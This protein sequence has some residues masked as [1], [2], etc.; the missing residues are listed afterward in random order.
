MF[1]A[2]SL[3]WL[4]IFNRI[5]KSGNMISDHEQRPTNPL[6]T[7]ERYRESNESEQIGGNCKYCKLKIDDDNYLECENCNGMVHI[8]CLHT[9]TP[10]DF[11]GDI[12]FDF[13]CITCAEEQLKQKGAP[14]THNEVK[15]RCER[16]KIPWLMVLTLTLYNLSHKQKGLGHH[17]FFHWRT[18]IISFVDRNWHYIFGPN[19][20]R[21]KKWTGSVSGTLSHNSPKYFMS[22][23]E[24]FNETGWWKLAKP[25]QTPRS[26]KR[27]YERKLELRVAMRFDK[28]SFLGDEN[29]C[30]SEVDVIDHSAAPIE[31]NKIIP[32]KIPAA[33]EA[34]PAI[35]SEGCARSIPYMGRK[36]RKAPPPVPALNQEVAPLPASTPVAQETGTGPATAVTEEEEEVKSPQQPLSSVQ[37]SLMDFLAESFGGDDLSM[38]SSLPGIMPPPLIG[39][40]KTDF[41]MTEALLESPSTS[42]GL[43]DM[44]STFGIPP[45]TSEEVKQQGPIIKEEP[46]AADLPADEASAES[47]EEPTEYQ[48]EMEEMEATASH[49]PRIV[50]VTSYQPREQSQRIKQEPMEE[51]MEESSSEALHTSS[52]RLGHCK[53]SGF[54]RQPRRNWPWLQETQEADEVAMPSENLALMSVYEEQ[55]LHQRLHRI[56]ALEQ[57]CQLSIPAYVRRLY[58]KLC[59]RK[60]KREHNRPIFNLDEHIDPTARARRKLE[61]EQQAQ[62]L[63]RYQLLAHSQQNP[64]SSFYA[65]LTGSTQYEMFESPYSQR[66]LHPFIFRSETMGPPWLKLM[67]ELQH[68]VNRCHPTR[69]PIDFCYVRPQHIPAVNALLQSAFWPNIDV[70]ECL[71]YP[72]YSVV[73]LYKKL[74]VGCGFLVPDVG[75]NEAYISFMAVRPNWQRSGIASFMLYHLIQTCMSKDITLHVSA[76]NPAV[77]LYQK[78]GFKIEEIIVDFYDK[79]LPL[80]SKQSRN[81]LFLRLLR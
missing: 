50:E 40:G 39:A 65:R 35:P 37:A 77:M 42:G 63:D 21:R 74:V 61:G 6:T 32:E 52:P 5:S 79:Y 70:S 56:F 27:E 48:K 53:P 55:K 72:D 49:P 76:S 29:S 26:T 13:T 8:K 2:Q 41:F 51:A 38:F 7:S 47:E 45:D 36:P 60:W 78:F 58:R 30:D 81:A 3:S 75:Y 59:L 67:C 46:M 15:E 43:F 69:S 25:N 64:K 44:D 10:G 18:H 1:S 31:E 20:R 9:S 24:Q 16:Q 68:R 73:A 22:G 11:L 28:R 34:S 66:V 71:S 33:A 4:V 62:I 23:M 14:Y 54:I 19:T 57:Q 17:G 80:D 12:Y